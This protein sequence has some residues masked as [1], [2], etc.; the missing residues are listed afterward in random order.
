MKLLIGTAGWSYK[1]W[2]GVVY[3]HGLKRKQ[4]P[5]EYLA[6]FVDMIEVNTS[7]YGHIRPEWGKLWCGKARGVNPDFRFTAKLHKSFTH[8]PVAVVQSTSAETIRMNDEDE[9]LAK[10][11]FDS[12]AQEH[13][14]GAVLVQFPVSFKNTNE[15]RDHVELVLNK[16][17]A[18][19]LVVE[20]RHASWN[21][22]G[23][24]KYFTE[25]GVSFC[26]I[27]QP[28]LGQSLRSTEHVTA[29]IGYVRL[30]GRN[31]K[32]WFESDNRDDRYNY[33]YRTDELES[34]KGRIESIAKKADVTFVVANN[35]FQGKA[36]V[37]AIQLKQMVGQP[38]RAPE[39]LA[40]H[41]P[42]LKESAEVVAVP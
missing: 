7:F 1:D 34:W 25:K 5:I 17:R 18:Y 38:A 13:M 27:D 30:H 3:P 20:V 35:H 41:Y 37:N 8:S 19:P 22:E 12:L 40:E 42:E 39:I 9:R 15:N 16:F 23:I 10:E 21:N 2:D 31:Y 11:G 26:N 33:L 4:H 14:L 28:R 24:L 29:S 32:E 36:V 6:R